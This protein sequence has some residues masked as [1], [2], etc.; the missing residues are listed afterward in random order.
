MQLV[1]HSESLF[2]LAA[3]SPESSASLPASLGPLRLP[4]RQDHRWVIQET[5]AVMGGLLAA[6]AACA[7]HPC[8]TDPGPPPWLH[9]L[10]GQSG[11]LSRPAGLL[12]QHT[13]CFGLPGPACGHRSPPGSVTGPLGFTFHPLACLLGFP[14]SAAGQ[15]AGQPTPLFSLG[16]WLVFGRVCI[17]S[18]MN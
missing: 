15:E 16:P 13:F 5:E 11:L 4:G 2:A 3:R 18:L 9:F 14:G 8:T 7:P 1:I 12:R 10:H 17:L 6:E